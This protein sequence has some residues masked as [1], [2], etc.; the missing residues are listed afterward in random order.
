MR[1]VP[2]PSVV[3]DAAFRSWIRQMPCL[4][5]DREPCECGKYIHVG[6]RRMVTE[7][8]HVRTRRNN[9]DMEN[10]VPLCASH[11]KEQHRVGIKTFQAR[12]HLDLKASAE[13]LWDSYQSL[14]FTPEG[15]ESR[16][17]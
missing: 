16:N 13:Q 4:L 9:G 11:H 15:A 12:H 8:C 1:S 14:T 17:E 5:A 2:K 6:S 10:L 7:A 3:R